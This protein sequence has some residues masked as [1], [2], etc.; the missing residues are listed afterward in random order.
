MADPVTIKPHSPIDHREGHMGP[1]MDPCTVQEYWRRIDR[2]QTTPQHGTAAC[3]CSW[4]LCQ[5]ARDGI[6]P[7]GLPWP[8]DDR[9][10]AP[11]KG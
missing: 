4:W 5:R 7:D 2:Q 11:V 8:V 3:G 6:G 1:C 10:Q 9:P